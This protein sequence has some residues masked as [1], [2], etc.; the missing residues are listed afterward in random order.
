MYTLLLKKN[1][2][3]NERAENVTITMV[4]ETADLAK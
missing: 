2:V 3:P 1:K 4:F